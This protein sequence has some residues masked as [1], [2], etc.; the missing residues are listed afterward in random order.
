M[1]WNR[2]PPIMAE[3]RAAGQDF[4]AIPRAFTARDLR[5]ANKKTPPP[6][7]DGVFYVHDI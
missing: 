2:L 3:N 5:S 4:V 6:E 1:N 7:G